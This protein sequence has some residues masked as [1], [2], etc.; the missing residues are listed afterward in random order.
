MQNFH[1]LM[2]RHFIKKI[3]FFC[4]YST[5]VVLSPSLI[6]SQVDSH[7]GLWIGEALLNRVSEVSVPL[8]EN[9]VPQ[10]PN[11]NT[12]TQ[13]HDLASLR[14]IIHVDASGNARFLKEV[15]LLKPSRLSGDAVTDQSVALVTDPSLYSQ[16]PGQPGQRFASA[17]FDYGD[18]KTSKVLQKLMDDAVSAAV[19]YGVDPN[20]FTA[21]LQE[22]SKEA[23]LEAANEVFKNAD[24]NGAFNDYLEGYISNDIIQGHINNGTVFSNPNTA[25][26]SAPYSDSRATDMVAVLNTILNSNDVSKKEKMNNTAAS[27]VDLQ[28]TYNRFIEGLYF[29]EMIVAAADAAASLK[30][31]NGGA[32]KS[33]FITLFDNVTK[34]NDAKTEALKIKITSLGLTDSRG[35]DAIDEIID[36]IATKAES[37]LF[38]TAENFRRDLIDEG[39]RSLA[40]DVLRYSSPTT[41]PSSEYNAFIASA[42]FA[43]APDRVSTAVSEAVYQERSTATFPSET[44]YNNVAKLAAYNELESTFALAAR[45]NVSELLMLGSIA[46]NSV[47]VTIDLPAMHPTNPFRHRRNPDHVKGLDISRVVTLN[48]TST[49]NNK[50]EG[51]YNE[52]IKGLHKLLGPNQDTGLKVAGS[53][54][55]FRVSK[56]ASLNGN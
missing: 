41:T 38:V 45:A 39:E 43:S 25:Q 56:V 3:K 40:N 22:R 2:Q 9:N 37:S 30:R 12:P 8:D 13:T 24:L 15:A 42:L 31:T 27:F 1:D 44:S 49:S 7:A 55:L 36:D 47:S 26:S 6:F 17:A 48:I 51:D 23:A 35:S 29:S 18:Q 33:E 16:F 20:V 52:E 34:I 32:T 54:E 50:I 4:I 46:S 19:S 10:A 28:N 53:F 5:A 21:L 14:L 11:P